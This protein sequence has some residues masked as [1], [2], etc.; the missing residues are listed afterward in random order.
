[1]GES[2]GVR[3]RQSEG[4]EKLGLSA[5]GLGDLVGDEFGKPNNESVKHFL[6]KES[7]AEGFR[8]TF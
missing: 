4:R 8:S 3:T 7:G 2:G 1:M 6:V 5:V